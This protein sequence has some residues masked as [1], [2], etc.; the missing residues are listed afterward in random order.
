[1]REREKMIRP[2]GLKRQLHA[3][4]KAIRTAYRQAQKRREAG[5]LSP[6][7]E[8]LTDHFHRLES[9]GRAA[10]CGLESAPPLPADKAGSVRIFALCLRLCAQGILPGQEELCRSL[11]PEH[12]TVWETQLLPLMLRVA[13]LH[14]AREAAEQPDGT[15]E[16]AVRS[17]LD[18]EEFDF[19]QI[20]AQI[21]ETQRIL[22]LDPAGLYPKMDADT[23]AHYRERAARSAAER[24]IPESREASELLRRARGASPEGVHIGFPLWAHSGRTGR[25]RRIRGVAALVIPPVLALITAVLAAALSGRWF[26]ALF[27][28][29]LL[30]E[31]FSHPV[32]AL[33]AYGIRPEPLPKMKLDGA[34]PEY[35]RTLIVVS[36]LLPPAARAGETAAHLE[37]LYRANHQGAVEVLLLADYKGADTPSLPSDE[38][39]YDAMKR[40]IDRLNDRHAGG[41]LLAVRDR[42]YSEAQGC[43]TGYERKRGAITQLIQAIRGEE[44]PQLH[45]YGCTG[46]LRTVKYLILLDADTGLP[47][48]AA[49]EMVRTAIHPLNRPRIDPQT[50]R[51]TDGYGILVPE[52][53]P[54]IESARATGF[55]RVMA[56]AGGASSYDAASA[57]FYQDCFGQTVFS[58]KGLVDVD[59]FYTVMR[60]RIEE[61]TVLSHDILEGG[62]LRAG[63]LSGVTVTDA[64]PSREEPYLRRMHRW[65]RGDWQN[66][67]FLKKRPYGAGSDN[68]TGRLTKYQLFDNLRRSFT[69]AAVWITL[70]AAPFTGGAIGALMAAAALVCSAAGELFGCF[71]A[72]LFGGFRAFSGRF[73]ARVLPEAAANLAR[74]G[75]KM[76]S[77]ARTGCIC[78]DAI[79]RSLWRTI[80]SRK[81][82]LEWTTAADSEKRKSSGIRPLLPSLLTGLYLIASLE[83]AL[84]LAGCTQLADCFF[85]RWSAKKQP[86]APLSDPILR[87]YASTCAAAQWRYYTEYA[88]ASDNFLPPDNVQETPV[89]RVAHRTSPTNIGMLLLCTL[90]ARD[91]GFIGSAELYTRLHNTISTVERLEKFRGNLLNWYDTRTL[92][93]MK[94]LYVSTVDSGNFLGCITALKNGLSEYVQEEPRLAGLIGR[95]AR[96]ADATDLYFLYHEKKNLF[97]IGYDLE[98]K[99]LTP[100]CYDLLMSE[101]RLTSYY[102][103]ARR[104]VPKKHWAA[105][106]RTLAR[107]GSYAGPVSWTGTM[108]EYY[109]PHLLLPAYENTLLNEALRFCL[110]CHRER[111]RGRGIPWGISESGF[112]AFDPALN[113]QYEAHGVQKLGLKQGL[114]DD[115]VIAPYATFLTLPFVPK[116]AFRN[117]KEIEELEMTGRCGFY[118]AVDFTPGR[119][120][121][122]DYAVVRSYMA[123]HVGM[124]M[125]A[126]DNAVRGNIMQKRFMADGDM[127]AAN[128][129]LEEKVQQGAV[130]FDDIEH[131][132]P[133]KR[134]EIPA[135]G[136]L[137]V[138]QIDRARPQMALLSNGEWNTAVTDGGVSCSLYRGASMTFADGDLLRRPCGIF[139]V[140]QAPGAQFP[141]NKA[142]AGASAGETTFEARFT[143]DGA[144]LSAEQSA[145]HA[146]M[147]VLVHPRIPGEIRRF[148]VRSRRASRVQGRLLVYLEPSLAAPAD[149]RAHP[150]FSR[151]FLT[152]EYDRSLHALL[153]TRR[154]RGEEPALSLAV[155]LADGRDFAFDTDRVHFLTRPQGIFSIVGREGPLDCR[156]AVKDVCAAIEIPFDIPPKGSCRAAVVMTAAQTVQ[157][158]AARLIRARADA[159]ATS[160]APVPFAQG[161]ME[162][163][164]LTRM[165]PHLLYTAQGG[166]DYD[167]AAAENRC[168]RAALWPLGISG[169]LPIILSHPS[170]RPEEMAPY[171]RICRR[172]ALC[173]LPVDLVLLDDGAQT[174]KMREAVRTCAQQNGCSGLIGARGG[175]HLI[176]RDQAGPE[177]LR[178]L[179]A[180]ARYFVPQGAEPVLLPIPEFEP[181][182]LC[183]V[184]PPKAAPDTHQLP[185]SGGAFRG[186]SFTVQQQPQVP[187]CHVLANPQFGT[188]VSDGA[189]GYTWAVNARENKLTPWLNDPCADNRGELLLLRCADKIYDL[190][191]GAWA[192]FSPSGAQWSGEAGGVHTSVTVTV[193]PRGSVKCVAVRLENHTGAALDLACAYYIEPV[194]GV[195][196]ET[197]RMIRAQRQG[198]GLLLDNPYAD[199]VP[200]FAWLGAAGGMDCYCCDR[201]RFLAGEWDDARLLPLTDPCAAV[202]KRASLPQG[203]AL[204]LQFYLAFSAHAED[205]PQLIADIV[206]NQPDAPPLSVQTPD[207][208]LDQLINTWLPHQIRACRIDARTA[209]YQCGG[210]W[211]LRDQLQ[212]AG[213]LLLLDSGVLQRQI[214]RACT[215]QFPQGDGLHWWHEFTGDPPSVRGVRT[216]YSDDYVWIAYETARYCNGTGDLDFLH[217]QAPYLAGEELREEEAERYFSPAPSGETG[218]VYEH[219]VRA[220]ERALDRTG[221]HG[222]PLIGGGDWNDGYNRVGWRGSGE[223]VWL[224]QF[225]AL[226]LDSF[227]PLCEQMAE[228]WRGRHFR[229]QAERLR[230]CVEEHCYDGDRYLRA[231]F[232]SGEPL[233][234]RGANACAVD[235]LTQSFAVLCGQRDMTRIQTALD[236]AVRELSD[237][238]HRLIRLFTPPFDGGSPDPGYVAAYPPGVREN[239][240]Q[241]THAAVWLCMALL[242]AGRVDEGYALL[243]QINPAAICADPEAGRRYRGEPYALAG[244]VTA[245][246]R[247]PGQAGWTQYTGSAGWFYTAAVEEL[248]GLRLEGGALMVQPKLPASWDGFEADYRFGKNTRV[249][250]TV[251]RGEKTENVP[252]RIPADGGE[253]KIVIT[254][255]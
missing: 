115:L 234:A 182:E 53:A 156:L 27:L 37:A 123:H 160:G 203:A 251:R 225:L 134:P 98:Q 34:V 136:V 236:T 32:Q 127:A 184:S 24:G 168:G 113:Y 29:P 178:C 40:E 246:P 60:G 55:S 68:P 218:S 224:A 48:N 87:E 174:E 169:D 233:G 190:L 188:L 180:S 117:L 243:C 70:L 167:R 100:A 41:F 75:V 189:L 232:D 154:P 215:H 111:V 23:Q 147:E 61:G 50:R 142:L 80:V 13:L 104:I 121:G 10:L 208:Y 253:H 36:D 242:R 237:S 159:A 119:T 162:G 152:V 76:I 18:L 198:D 4:L 15:V 78:L 22:M 181:A 64:F 157:E 133:P 193:P 158:A 204:E 214:L 254:I 143:P 230:Q 90:A 46:H 235:S 199:G 93:P 124:S 239:G 38:A 248:L 217:T 69:S 112:Y 163:V 44:I 195:S 84:I 186:D 92:R 200:G 109:M 170:E 114:D 54:S 173:G 192:S 223:S 51:V 35:A 241:Y 73:Y 62:F 213:A 132:Q 137:D 1:M 210:A 212:D 206:E 250:L 140:V 25:T 126:C 31:I 11:A 196:R 138:Y 228:S 77:A 30:W 179:A 8:W 110:H 155:G 47:F 144:V 244:D 116:E 94:P 175:V 85:D 177:S 226:T 72:L 107:A 150:A 194:L 105:L 102:A 171:L 79:L 74:A 26:L 14:H 220:L 176:H 16:N 135:S 247:A 86:D 42:T 153:F 166:P 82:M 129:I 165:L 187:W 125:L 39:D 221:A 122:Q 106:G 96:L 205:F 6:R 52:I 57:N 95:I 149:E 197:A 33:L 151:L 19:E 108:F 141:I 209:F 172:L 227:A 118:E 2:S 17:L 71:T 99:Q 249:H 81:K 67:V 56:G 3:D 59:A 83:W 103:V 88:G 183:P 185:V 231:F 146:E 21:N 211:G 240:G 12:L 222:L 20:A 45:L 7:V 164:L 202:C 201:T 66:I 130:F 97:H 229:E 245:S 216:R 9:A 207:P 139:G 128:T 238:E 120:Q 28:F 131:E 191:H 91:F 101:A 148:T 145:L 63:F 43:Y 58:G 161:S 255:C 65:V 89:A 49:L 252:L 219:A 5:E